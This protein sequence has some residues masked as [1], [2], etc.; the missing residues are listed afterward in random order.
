[1]KIFLQIIFILF[2]SKFVKSEPELSKKENEITLKNTW[3]PDEDENI[4]DNEEIKSIAKIKNLDKKIT[5]R[6]YTR[7]T[8]DNYELLKLNDIDRL[9]ASHFNPKRPT[10]F[11]SHGWRTAISRRSSLRKMIREAFLE[12]EDCNLIMIT[13]Y[14]LSFRPYFIIRKNIEKMGRFI[15]SFINFLEME[16]MNLN[17]TTL[18]GLSLG[19]HVVGVTGYYTKRKVNNIIGLDPSWYL[20]NSCGWRCRI[21]T[22]SGNNVEI[23]HTNDN[24]IGN[25]NALGH[26]DFYPNGGSKQP[27]CIFDIMGL[28]S[29]HRALLY[30]LESL[31][32]KRGFHAMNCNS[33]NHFLSGECNGHR[34]IMGGIDISFKKQG[35]YYLMTNSKI[36][37]AK[38]KIEK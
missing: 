27:G 31:S 32:T 34:E 21:S 10:K 5:F 16:E 1:M 36:P 26:V 7:E 2:V 25:P 20:Y 24:L 30:Y 9:K 38:G 18:I 6:L 22:Q 33:Y 12:S 17:S 28:C 14:K 19:S 23:I 35:I 11:F 13:W 37:Y 8:G 4:L 3:I 29:H 15:A